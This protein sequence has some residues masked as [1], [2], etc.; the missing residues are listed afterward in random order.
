M[1]RTLRSPEKVYGL[2]FSPEEIRQAV[3]Q[4]RL[5]TL[6]LETS[7]VCNL[8]CVYCY[9]N[10]GHKRENELSFEEICGVIDQA[11]ELGVKNITIIGGGEPML[12]PNILDIIDYIAQ[13]GITQNLFTNGTLMT[14]AE[15]DFIAARK[16]SIVT[17]F[18]SLK[19]EV[20]DRL[21][22]VPGTYDLIH[23][24]IELLVEHGYSK[25]P[26]LPLGLETIICKHNYDELPEMWRYARQRNMHPYF[27]VITF[28][29]RAKGERLNVE[30][31]QLKDLFHR[32]L[33]IDEQEFGFT[34]NPHPP[35]AGLSCQRHFYNLLVTSNGYIHPC[36]GVD[37]N[38][39]NVR[40]HT[41]REVLDTSPV[42]H[43]L[44]RID[45]H[46][47]GKCRACR[48][49]DECYGCRG[50]AYHY[51]GDFLDADPTCWVNESSE[52]DRPTTLNR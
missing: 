14:P 28:Q 22:G 10:S 34:W 39:G 4:N 32:L 1:D 21:A 26:E 2:H 35:I 46:I 12:H 45:Q 17:K 30:M 16:V 52:G 18:N 51:C 13:Q 43:A 33:E 11:I 25:D 23:K 7:R 49:K 50:F 37:V 47:K 48:Y 38:V 44:R 24:T 27:E 3:A 6:D 31:E 15:A 5:L 8:R 42:I 20:Q 41:L 29:G 19:S 40:H 36:T 9:A